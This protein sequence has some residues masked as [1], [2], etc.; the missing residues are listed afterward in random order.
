MVAELKSKIINHIQSVENEVTLEMY[1]QV[2]Q[3]IGNANE[4]NNWSA[5]SEY[6]KAEI[7]ASYQQSQKVIY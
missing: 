1:Y 5:L 3:A 6:H 2:I 7:L 4:S